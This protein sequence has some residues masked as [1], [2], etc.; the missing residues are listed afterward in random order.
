MDSIKAQ[1]AAVRQSCAEAA[2]ALEVASVTGGEVTDASTLRRMSMCAVI[3]DQEVRQLTKAGISHFQLILEQSHTTVEKIARVLRPSIN[4][5]VVL[6]LKESPDKITEVRTD[7]ALLNV[8]LLHLQV[9]V[10]VVRLT[11]GG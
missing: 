10:A 1:I 3:L 7:G 4:Q 8:L 11:A 5:N 2:S 6:F 9:M